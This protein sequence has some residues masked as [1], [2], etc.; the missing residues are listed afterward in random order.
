[1]PV[2]LVLD[3]KVSEALWR[4]SGAF[5]NNDDPNDIQ[6]LDANILVKQHG[7]ELTLYAAEGRDNGKIGQ[8]AVLHY[9]PHEPIIIDNPMRGTKLSF[10]QIFA[11]V[12]I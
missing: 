2:N 11:S 1:M 5:I 6:S 12:K 10:K 4:A 8:H 7:N 9:T 3:E